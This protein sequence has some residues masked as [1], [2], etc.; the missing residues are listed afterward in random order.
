[1][2]HPLMMN[3]WDNRRFFLAVLILQ[4][5]LWIAIGMEIPILREAIGFFT[6]SLVPGF[7]MLRILKIHGLAA[8]ETLLYAVGLSLVV[9]F[10]LGLGLNVFGPLLGDPGPITLPTLMLSFT[11]TVL[12]L[13]ILA[14]RLG[15]ESGPA[16]RL[17]LHTISAPQAL[18]FA[19][20]PFCSVF[21][22]Y[23]MNLYDINTV[24]LL[25]LAII[26][27]IGVAIASDR[28]F[29]GACLPLAVYTIALSLLWHQSLISPH[30]AGWDIQTEYYF[31]HLVTA[32]GIWNYG[33]PDN[34]N[35]MLSIVVLAPA[36]SLICGMDLVWVYKLLYPVLYALVPL[37][38]YAIYRTQKSPKIAFY[39]C[40]IFMSFFVFFQ[41]MLQLARQQI[42]ELFL[43]LLIL[44]MVSKPFDSTRRNVLFV[45]F[46]AGMIVSHYATSY[47][48]WALLVGGWVLLV[49]QET[50]SFRTLYRVFRERVDRLRKRFLF[51]EPDPLPEAE[52]PGRTIRVPH[53]VV[54]FALLLAWYYLVTDSSVL[55][56]IT[57]LSGQIADS[58]ISDFLNP[59]LAE[60]YGL[61][62]W[63]TRS[64]LHLTAKILHILIQG[65]IIVGV[66]SVVLRG[67][68]GETINREYFAF[69]LVALAI[70]F[71]AL[72]VP[73]F[74]EALNT[75]R[76][77]H[78]CLTL[79][80]PFAVIGAV[81][82]LSAGL[83][84]RAGNLR[85]NLTGTSLQL[86]SILFVLFFLF[87]T[88]V[89]YEIFQDDPQ[90]ISLNNNVEYPRF[91]ETEVVSARW[92]V[93][94]HNGTRIYADKHRSQLLKGFERGS[95]WAFSPEA[96]ADIPQNSL[97]FLG[98]TN[99]LKKILVIDTVEE[100]SNG[101][102]PE[103]GGIDT[104]AVTAN[105]HKIYSSG[106][107][108]IYS[109]L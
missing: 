91:T 101:A 49:L 63:N 28:V 55:Q 51:D 9:L 17:A 11:L 98:R 58:L 35:A 96:P 95:I 30:L 69:S 19:F 27:F 71:A 86:A 92:A 67:R 77:Y 25:L 94:I 39:S 89:V 37:G 24:L 18:F 102:E 85:Q 33:I 38:L 83:A 73:F 60:G 29:S 46:A 5:L 80:A 75:T 2:I 99:L 76:I 40:F 6:I 16:P 50:A 88:G 20:L 64:P 59:E 72:G 45:L 109:L 65:L 97:I 31:S 13:S 7:L 36:Y 48:Y 44:L 21:G 53:L 57:T 84:E 34:V 10:L 70:L 47:F 1:M 82:L 4:L 105:S 106:A 32:S 3:D 108:A 103:G 78:L 22:T 74:A 79:L 66:T 12:F 81:D 23:V 42:A 41:E 107:A 8:T 68:R 62:L 14:A 93:A 43:V 100:A 61:L 52:K 56:S 104:A 87:N 26:A 54:Y 90:S 15:G